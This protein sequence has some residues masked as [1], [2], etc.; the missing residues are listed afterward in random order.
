MTLSKLLVSVPVSKMFQTLYGKMV[1]THET[2]VNHVQSDSRKVGRNDMFVAIRGT[3][4]DG[5]QYIT[6]AIT[7]GA[8]VVVTDND[9]A[10]PDSYFMHAGVVKVVVA[11]ARIALA[12]I[13]KNYFGNSSKSL[14][15][16]GITGTN[17]KT[18]C[19]FLTCTL[20]ESKGKSGLIGTIEYRIGRERF[21]ASHTTP[22]SL[23]LQQLFTRMVSEGCISCVMEV[24]S[25]ALHQ[26]RVLGIEYQ[27]GVFT[28]LTQDHLD[29]HRTMDEYFLAKKMLFDS[30]PKSSTAVINI[31]DEW[32]RK[33]SQ[34]VSCTKLSYGTGSDAELRASNISLSVSGTSFQLEF[35]TTS[36]TI[37]TPLVGRFNVYNALA[38]I[39][40]GYAM[41]ISF[42]EIQKRF[43]TM[44]PVPGRFEQIQSPMGWTAIVD[45]A[46]TPDALE[47]ALRA[48][49]DVSG[50]NRKGKI[51][52]VFGCGGNRDV[53]KRPKMA[54]VAS[55]LSDVVIVTSDNPRFEEPEMIIDQVMEGILLQKQTIREADRAGAISLALHLAKENDII[56]IAGKGHEDYQ[57]IGDKKHPF[58][59][60]QRV[61]EYIGKEN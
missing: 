24:S 22:D 34:T 44:Q 33:L 25:H 26:H 11:D 50:Q 15:K 21:P 35:G 47:K 5:N 8:K 30:L 61:L 17:G 4:L 10:V 18:T 6:Q 20:M 14:E 27:V 40:A 36:F 1:V 60:K 54:R 52:T 31:D 2:E 29:Y 59:D 45:Y 39:G 19:S 28:N 13:A 53:T 42:D 23:E 49:H 58:S 43:S 9:T 3:G 56:L 48:I 46:H 12:Q 38:S 32:G 16:I 51:I 7:N 55:E 41:G 37:Q 57:I